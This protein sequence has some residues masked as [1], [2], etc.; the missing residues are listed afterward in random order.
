MK[1]YEIRIRVDMRD[2]NYNTAINIIT[3]DELNKIMPLIDMIKNFKPY[4]TL[5]DNSEDY[6]DPE[7]RRNV[8]PVE[9]THRSNFPY[10]HCGRPD[11]G[12]KWAYEYSSDVGEEVF[13]LFEEFLPG[14]EPG[15]YTIESIEICEKPSIIKLL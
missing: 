4:K 2:V 3:E 12:Q 9:F 10:G 7:R 13:E 14:C 1:E 6:E 8:E 11:L 5:V 15:F